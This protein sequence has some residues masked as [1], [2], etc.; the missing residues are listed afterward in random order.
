MKSDELHISLHRA[1]I[2][3][4]YALFIYV[5]RLVPVSS[6]LSDCFSTC[7]LLLLFILFLLLVFFCLCVPLLCI[8]RPSRLLLKHAENIGGIAAIL[9]NG[10][11]GNLVRR[12]LLPS[13]L[14]VS[15][16]SLWSLHF[17]LGVVLLSHIT[18]RL[19]YRFCRLLQFALLRFPTGCSICTEIKVI[20]K[21]SPLHV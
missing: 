16:V 2:F 11:R 14:D 10:I 13:S 20:L 3:D 21:V 12:C 6:L 1:N 18:C 17:A 7:Q 4:F 9:M 5:T 15:A 8:Y 19:L